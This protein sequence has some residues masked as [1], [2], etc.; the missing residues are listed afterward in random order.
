MS[1][2][3]APSSNFFYHDKFEEH[4]KM[5]EK[6]MQNITKIINSNETNIENPFGIR[7]NVT[8]S[9]DKKNMNSFL[10]ED[11]EFID[12]LIWNNCAKLIKKYNERNIFKLNI[13]KSIIKEG[14]FNYYKKN[15]FQET[16]AHYGT[17]YK[18]DDEI[19]LPSF[20]AIYILHDDNNKNNTTFQYKPSSFTSLYI[21]DL[22]NIDT[23]LIDDICEG[24]IIIFPFD[25]YHSVMPSKKKRIT[26]SFNIYSSIEE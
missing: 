3:Y 19:Y 18:K 5:K 6:I 15:N 12:K 20:S 13:K 11:H 24:S 16:H 10:L 26:L 4:E 14:W 22:G 1:I 2:I 9:Y 17:P 8:S 23:S 25:Y 21:D 7:C